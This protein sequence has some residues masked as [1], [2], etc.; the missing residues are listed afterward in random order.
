MTRQ[1]TTPSH[2]LKPAEYPDSKNI[3]PED[4]ESVSR[5]WLES[6][7]GALE[8]GEYTLLQDLFFAESF[9][10]DQLSLSW[11]NHTLRGSIEIVSFLR[12]RAKSTRIGNLRL[13]HRQEVRT[14]QWIA[15]DHHGKHMCLMSFLIFDIDIATGHGVLR[16]MQDSVTGMW[17]AFTLFTAM[18]ELKGYEESTKNNRPLGREVRT[19]GSRDVSYEH[20]L[21]SDNLQPTVVI[22]GE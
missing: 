12:S 8:A 21:E 13:N 14:P 22:V 7:N 5:K 15:I 2:H 3:A 16:L 20:N 19:F 18:K 11:D 17:K 6:F 1:P 9:W 4:A 10:K